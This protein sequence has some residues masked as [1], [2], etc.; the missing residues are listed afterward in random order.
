MEALWVVL[1]AML[2]V[3]TG[4][5]WLATRRAYAGE[6]FEGLTPGLLPAPGV[7]VARL[8]LVGG[9]KGEIAVAFIPPVGVR[10]GLVGPLLVGRA[11]MRDVIATIVDLAV[12]GFLTITIVQDPDAPSGRDW[13]LARCWSAPSESLERGERK[14]RDQLFA[15]GSPVRLSSF[16]KAGPL[17]R[18][19]KATRRRSSQ[20]G[21][22]TPQVRRL[23]YQPTDPYQPTDLGD[24]GV[25][26]PRD[27]LSWEFNDHGWGRILDRKPP[28]LLVWLGVG[29][30]VALGVVFGDSA[31]VLVSI[32]SAV[33]GA[34]MVRRVRRRPILSAE[35]T[36][37]Q[38]Q[39]R[40]F[41]KYLATAE[42]E[43]FSY[44]EAAGIFSRYLPYAI[45][46][47]VAEHWTKVFGELAQQARVEGYQGDFDLPWVS[48]QAR[49]GF[50][51]GVDLGDVSSFGD[52]DGGGALGLADVLDGGAIDGVGSLDGGSVGDGDGFGG[53]VGDLVGFDGGFGGEGGGGDGGGGDGGGGGGEGG[54]G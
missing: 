19:Q 42:K 53:L 13:E 6:I 33:L 36:A 29:G 51:G 40:G 31:P 38:I 17:G 5:M 28:L 16:V 47:G 34:D 45:S 41:E 44:E 30:L 7:D 3:L 4:V 12:R 1:G 46:L 52:V 35:G 20:K 11:R 48:V 22:R 9:Y 26:D 50:A 2:L 49:D 10:P 15:H 54:V 24:A 23:S 27:T 18:G 8:P 43:Q 32:P 14:L 39:L 37:M 21:R 25:P